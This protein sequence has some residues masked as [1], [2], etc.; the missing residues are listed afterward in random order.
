MDSPTA[1][2]R[3][4]VTVSGELQGFRMAENKNVSSCGRDA[5]TRSE[6]LV[7]GGNLRDCSMHAS[8][9]QGGIYTAGGLKECDRS[10]CRG[11]PA[12]AISSHLIRSMN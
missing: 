7:D 3:V 4:H 8:Q 2:Y 12:C 1:E 5:E 10:T 6:I 11:A 9:R